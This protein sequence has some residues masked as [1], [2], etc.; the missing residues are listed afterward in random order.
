MFTLTVTA[1][2]WT[3]A[4]AKPGTGYLELELLHPILGE[5]VTTTA[6]WTARLSADGTGAW[7]V[8]TVPAGNALKVRSRVNGLY[9]GKTFYFADPG[10]GTHTL[11]ELLQSRQVD[12]KTLEPSE[13]ALAGWQQAVDTTAQNTVVATAAAEQ[14]TVQR[15]LAE[16]ALAAAGGYATDAGTSAF[17]AGQS[18]ATALGHANHAADSAT[19]A[20]TARQ[21]AENIAAGIPALLED[22]PTRDE[23][24]ATYVS[25]R[26]TNGNPLAA[27]HVV[28][29]VN[30]TTGEIAD[31]IAEVVA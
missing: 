4:G 25:F 3:E 1:R 24:S 15:A 28:I 2:D 5:Q 19:A 20:D 7:E 16:E 30:P 13:E 14:A 10:I 27:R 29:T 23:V 18:A 22:R 31:I 12:P 17:N 8:P 26:D 6:R 9:Q 21:D 11:T